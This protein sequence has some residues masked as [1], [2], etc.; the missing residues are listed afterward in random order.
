MLYEMT[1]KLLKMPIIETS[2]TAMRSHQSSKRFSHGVRTSGTGVHL[3]SDLDDDF[4]LLK[5]FASENANDFSS[6][7]FKLK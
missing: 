2:H 7:F 5:L 4:F 3:I 1:H 6:F